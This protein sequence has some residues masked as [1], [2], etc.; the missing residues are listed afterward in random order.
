MLKNYIKIALK[1]LMRRKLIT[2][3]NL[4]GIVFTLVVLIIVTAVFYNEYG[5]MPPETSQDRILYVSEATLLAEGYRSN[6]S[7]SYE[8]LMN[9]V[10][11]HT[12][13]HTE[14]VS[15]FSRYERVITYHDGQRFK[16]YRKKTD[17]AF[18][19]IMDFTFL[20]GRP[21]TDDDEKNSRLVAV[22]S[23]STRRKLYGN[24]KANGTPKRRRRAI[25]VGGTKFVPMC[26]SLTKWSK[27]CAPGSNA[28]M[29]RRF[30]TA[31]WTLTWRRRSRPAS[32][33]GQV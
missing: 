26:C 5:A 19:E 28:A 25:L 31:T 2:F 10:N 4:F 27:T 23:E 18:W 20:E 8:F 22:I 13:P 9:M 17:G 6:G 1:V 32:M 11:V 7:P 14:K 16:F 12:L 33:A 3:I 29:R 15:I 30:W 21:I 24:E